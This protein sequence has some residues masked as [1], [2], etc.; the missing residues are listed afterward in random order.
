VSEGR[1]VG[2]HTAFYDFWCVENGKIVEHWDLIKPIMAES[3]RANQ[4]GKF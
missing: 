3:K 2:A 4:N 1:F